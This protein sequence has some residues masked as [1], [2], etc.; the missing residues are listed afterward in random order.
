[1]LKRIASEVQNLRL[2]QRARNSSIPIG[3]KE[4]NPFLIIS[5]GRSG[6]TLLR[7][8][9]TVHDGI[10]IP[11]ESD[12]LIPRGAEYFIANSSKNWGD[13]VKD[14]LEDFEK[15]PCFKFWGTDLSGTRDRLIGLQKEDRSYAK[16]IDC[17]YRNHAEIQGKDK[18]LWGDKTPYLMY[19]LDW[20]RLVF[21]NAR[22]IHLVRDG[23]AVTH[24]MMTKQNYTMQ[25]AST[26]WKDSIRMFDMHL[27]HVDSGKCLQIRYE[28][29]IEDPEFI[30]KKV[31][32]F[33][34]VKFKKEMVSEL[35]QKMGDNLLP[36]HEN[37]N[38][39]INKDLLNRWRNGLREEELL[40]LN[41]KLSKELKRLAYS[42]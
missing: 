29:L 27:A 30:L 8:M 11:P 26:R 14:I 28:D 34:S 7:R 3:N 38:K 41:E 21:P 33:L 36:H 15:S 20:L 31:C 40:Y 32:S 6:T 4:L 1:M 13:L 2:I 25:K 19:H 12:D 17:I 18:C 5:A 16:I 10:H 42:G 9:L 22:Y 35:P 24:S 37:S 39:S 23:R